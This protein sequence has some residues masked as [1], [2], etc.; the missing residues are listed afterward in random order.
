MRIRTITA[1]VAL[2][3]EQQD[4]RSV[5][6]PLLKQGK[7][8][9]ASAQGVLESKGYEVQ[10]TRIA[11]NPFP[12]FTHHDSVKDAAVILDEICSDNGMCIS[13]A[14]CCCRCSAKVT[15]PISLCLQGS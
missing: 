1:F 15:F 5:W 8:V 7:D 6:E 3:P 2:P 13:S 12:E 14:L 9:M 4:P 11:T 10:T